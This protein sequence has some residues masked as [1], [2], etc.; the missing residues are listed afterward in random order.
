KYILIISLLIFAPRA[1]APNIASVAIFY[2]PPV[3]SYHRLI[4][5]I[6]MAETRCDTLAFNDIEKATGYFQ[7]RPIRLEDYN[8]RTGSNY[9]LK[10]MFNY[11]TAEKVFLYY[12]EQ[13]GPYNFEKIARNWNGSGH[14]T[15]HYWNRVK[16]YL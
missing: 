8:R 7:I 4:Y 12:A 2:S 15:L 3:N 1:F 9:K 5:A 10:D 6:G 13:T 14:R 11:K 16:L